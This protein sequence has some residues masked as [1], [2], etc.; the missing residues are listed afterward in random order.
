MAPEGFR[1]A[2]SGKL[3]IE[4]DMTIARAFE[5]IGHCSSWAGPIFREIELDIR[6]CAFKVLA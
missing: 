3:S 6:C 2:K 1:G 5:K 4:I